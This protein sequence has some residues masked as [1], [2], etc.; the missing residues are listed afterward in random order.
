MAQLILLPDYSDL[1]YFKRKVSKEAN[2]IANKMFPQD[3][4]FSYPNAVI[5]LLNLFLRVLLIH[6]DKKGHY[7]LEEDF[8]QLNLEDNA[9]K[10]KNNGSKEEYKS[11]VKEIVHIFSAK[12]Y[13]L[14]NYSYILEQVRQVILDKDRLLREKY[15]LIEGIPNWK[16]FIEIV[17]MRCFEY[18]KKDAK[19]TNFIFNQWIAEFKIRLVS[20]EQ[21]EKGGKEGNGEWTTTLEW[22]HFNVSLDYTKWN[23]IKKD[24]EGVPAKSFMPIIL[25]DYTQQ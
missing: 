25:T 5:Y 16:H 20:V 23:E 9:E 24:E 12:T 7:K 15:H 22:E 3:Q 21:D 6:A 8:G 19:I 10:P 11:Y 4:L 13:N 14:L 18:K 17:V 1:Q 2:L